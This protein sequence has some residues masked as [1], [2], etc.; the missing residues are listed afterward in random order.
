[1]WEIFQAILKDKITPNQ[2]MLLYAFDQSLGV[3]Q[4]DT[5]SELRG[6]IIE[7]YMI[8]ENDQYK[9]TALG[10]VKMRKYDAYFIKAKNKTSIDLMGKEFAS[11]IDTYRELFPRQKLP[12]GKPAR[13]NIKTLTDGF[14]WFFDNFDYTW[15][16]VHAATRKY[17]NSY[18]DTGYMYMKN[19]QYFTVKTL[20]NKEKVSELADYCDIIREGTD[21]D[22]K[23]FQENVV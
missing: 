12:S 20:P 1:M 6:L 14:R 10:R 11:N 5:H 16:E 19:S 15:A 8:K 4:I 17:L 9:I 22:I 2:L 21:D 3:S 18:E 7:K 23:H 13:Q